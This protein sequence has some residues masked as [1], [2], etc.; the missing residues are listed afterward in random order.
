MKESE[1]I[2]EVCGEEVGPADAMLGRRQGRLVCRNADCQLLMAQLAGMPAASRASHLATQRERIL[3]R[4]ERDA[5]ARGHAAAIREAEVEVDRQILAE[6][7]RK[8]DPDG[9]VVVLPIPSGLA[10]VSPMPVERRER[11]RRH[12]ERTIE[13]AARASEGGV[14][15]DRD[16][17][18]RKRAIASGRFLDE[19]PALKARCDQACE[20]C[21]GGCCSVG[22]EHAFISTVTIRRL[23]DT[24]ASLGGEDILRAY[25]SHLPERSIEGA[26]VN[27]TATGCALP[28]AWRSDACNAYFCDALE[29][30]QKDWDEAQPPEAVLV[31]R[32]AYTNGNR[33][34]AATP[35]PVVEVAW[36]D[37]DGVRPMG[38][39]GQPEVRRSSMR[40]G[41]DVIERSARHG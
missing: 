27:Q 21:K 12:L 23:M 40:E 35:N 39:G 31:I 34:A 25:L 22:G 17:I 13:E 26:C 37:D 30:F 15:R 33:F 28:R 6:V 36:V 7:R 14:S 32:R 8:T 2:C 11:Y 4:R 19:R 16:H 41:S 18:A 10:T 5:R 38:A 20:L 3:D 9:R 29:A 24:D 1:S